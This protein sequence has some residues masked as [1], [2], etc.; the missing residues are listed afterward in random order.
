MPTTKPAVAI[1]FIP[2]PTCCTHQ[3][4]NMGIAYANG[5]RQG[6]EIMYGYLATK[7][8]QQP[9][10]TVLDEDVLDGSIAEHKAILLFGIDEPDPRVVAALE[11]YIAQGGLVIT[12]DCGVKIKGAVALSLKPRMPDQEE[13]G[14][15]HVVEEVRADGPLSDDDQDIPGRRAAGQGAEGRTRQGWDQARAGEQRQH[16]RRRASGRWRR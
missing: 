2:C 14:Q 6:Q 16:H 7:L 15:D 10:M 5:A 9:M 8:M 11:D 3:A 4:K 13:I 12:D 1:N